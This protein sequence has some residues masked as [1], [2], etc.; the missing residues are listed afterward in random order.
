MERPDGVD[1]VVPPATTEE[2][3]KQVQAAG[4]RRIWMQQG[5]ESEAAIRFC[6]HNEMSVIDGQCILTF[7]EPAAFYQRFHRWVWKVLGKLPA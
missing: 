3:V 5:P 6:R 2:V 1:T 7:A 4:I